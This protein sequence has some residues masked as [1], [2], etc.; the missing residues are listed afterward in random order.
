[1]EKIFRLLLA[2]VIVMIIVTVYRLN[3][4][5]SMVDYDQQ[6]TVCILSIEEPNTTQIET[7][8]SEPIET[9]NDQVIVKITVELTIKG[10]EKVDIQQIAPIKKE[11]SNLTGITYFYNKDIFRNKYS[12]TIEYDFKKM[13]AFDMKFVGIISEKD[14][15]YILL[16]R[17]IEN[18]QNF[19]YYCTFDI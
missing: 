17:R 16:N 7:Y 18:K 1:M 2:T 6:K 10:S 5:K 11:Y 12:E 8:I 15:P 13:S 9:Q 4:D 3:S 14:S 19:G